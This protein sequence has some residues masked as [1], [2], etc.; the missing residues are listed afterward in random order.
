VSARFRDRFRGTRA[1]VVT[2][3]VVAV[4]VGL[5]V[6]VAS[7][8]G[9]R[10]DAAD[11]KVVA[12]MG[13]GPPPRWS[14]GRP[15][16][17]ARYTGPQGVG[18]FV[19][20]CL[21]AHS[22]PDDPIVWPGRPGRS[23][24]HDFYGAIGVGA[25]STARTLAGN[26]S[27]CDKPG[28]DAAYWQPT[29]YDHAVPV[30]PLEA[31]AYYRAAPG[32]NPYDVQPFPF[33][34][35]LV[36]GDPTATRPQVGEAAG[37]TCGVRTALDKTPPACDRTAPLHL[38]LTF[39][40]C[41][42]GAHTDTPDHRA[43]ATYSEHGRCPSTHPVHIPQLTL[44][45]TFPVWG[46]DHDLRLASGSIYSAHGDFLNAWDPAALEREIDHCLRNNVM[47]DVASDREQVPPFFT[48]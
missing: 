16:V 21:Y 9:D 6:V 7:T 11:T 24:R 20:K 30:V 37:W 46:A 29:L 45:V 22:A 10:S 25:S 36:A 47:C 38:V 41:W 35:A 32:V 27:T 18:Q 26:G 12:P 48:R 2:A 13:L 23:H 39:P 44:T 14:D 31:H 19:A 40:D 43:Q 42:D 33:G 34:L 4:V 8:R 15:A 28:D 5:V 17:P 3:V 1:V